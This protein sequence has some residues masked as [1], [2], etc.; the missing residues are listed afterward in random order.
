M[1]E[2]KS[3]YI[4]SQNGNLNEVRD[5]LEDM[6]KEEGIGSFFH[7]KYGNR[8]ADIDINWQNPEDNGKTALI[9]ATRNGHLEVVRELIRAGADV[10]QSD[11]HDNVPI[12]WAAMHGFLEIAN[13][14][15][16][17]GA[18]VNKKNSGDQTAVFFA[19]QHNQ[20]DVLRLILPI[21]NKE[22]LLLEGF[23]D[24][25]A[26]GLYKTPLYV[27][28]EN[29]NVEAAKLLLDSV[30][31][32]M[33]RIM[34]I[35]PASDPDHPE[36]RGLTPLEIARQNGNED[37]VRLLQPY[38]VTINMPSQTLRPMPMPRRVGGRKTKKTIR[39]RRKTIRKRRKT[40]GKKRR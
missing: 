16:R 20:N 29:G 12:F 25:D 14:L 13:A 22:I 9:I 8:G 37:I 28:A 40:I 23:D 6:E 27:A 26:W 5:L 39:K 32:T 30:P 36:H 4:A 24:D 3:L 19:T 35:K 7:T 33:K 34:S 17:A 11:T 15:I 10:N 2:S 38:V 1:T 21:C 31:D 18:D